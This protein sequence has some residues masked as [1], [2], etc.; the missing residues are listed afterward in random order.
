MHHRKRA[1]DG[2][3]YDNKEIPFM[4]KKLFCIGL[5]ASLTSVSSHAVRLGVDVSDS[6]YRDYIVRFEASDGTQLNTCGGLLIA[7]EYILTA[8]HCVGDYQYSGR[9]YYDWWINNGASNSITVYQGTAFNATKRTS[10]TY[11]V[12]DLLSANAD[13]DTL[14]D[15]AYSEAQYIKNQNPQF[16]WSQHDFVYDANRTKTSFQHDI[17]LLKLSSPVTQ[18]SHAAI[19]PVFDETT[20]TFNVSP[21]QQFVFKG[22]GINESSQ[23]PDTMQKVNVTWRTDL[24]AWATGNW[25]THINYIPNFSRIW[26]TINQC[27]NNGDLCTY[28][29]LDFATLFPSS[30]GATPASGDS[31]TPLELTTNK[32]VALAKSV[33]MAAEP[34]YAQF[35]HLGWYL[36]LIAGQ[37]DAVTA[38]K[39][40]EYTFEVENTNISVPP[41]STTFAVQNLTSTAQTLAPFIQGGG[42]ETVSGC[43]NVTLQPT[44]SCEITVTFNGATQST[45]NLGDNRNTTLPI[46]LTIDVKTDSDNDNN[47]GTGGGSTG[48]TSGTGGGGGSL[49]WFSLLSV[50][51]LCFRKRK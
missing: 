20:Q 36:P 33:Q 22:W 18:L 25:I 31:G 24:P 28:G 12:L 1:Y 35:T 9:A 27:Q 14:R 49:G 2:F 48:G 6:E 19:A 43:D 8:G 5:I 15:K 45:L 4:N 37:I 32:V 23:T 39:R 47:G 17:A 10:T 30:I 41:F 26:T 44:Q 16:D 46:S 7:G 29:L 11:T 50:L 42:N 40:L 13:Y 51:G 34:E 3:N 21:N 38:P